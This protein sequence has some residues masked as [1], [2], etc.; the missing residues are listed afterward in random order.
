MIGTRV[1]GT[2]TRKTVKLESKLRTPDDTPLQG[3]SEEAVRARFAQRLPARIREVLELARQVQ[4]GGAGLEPARRAA[5]RLAG[6]SGAYG[7]FELSARLADLE[8][9]LTVDLPPQGRL[10]DLIDE[11]ARVASTSVGP[12]GA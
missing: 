5:H 1:Y 9:V 4:L 3:K 2:A 12:A 11:I 10:A 7:Y 8:D 6:T